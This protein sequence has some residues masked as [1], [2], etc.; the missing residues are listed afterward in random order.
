MCVFYFFN[1]HYLSRQFNVIHTFADVAINGALLLYTNI[2]ED[3]ESV[4]QEKCE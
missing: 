3:L 4:V 1:N 2:L